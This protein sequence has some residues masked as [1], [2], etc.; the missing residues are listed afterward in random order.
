MEQAKML[1]FEADEI[2][3]KEGELC[4]SMYK[5][6]SGSVILYIRYGEPDEQVVGIYSKSRCFG[7]MNI[8]TSQPSAYTVIAYDKVMLMRIEKD[9]LESFVRQ[10]PQNAIDIMNNMSKSLEMMQ[11]HMELLLD[12][13]YKKDEADK[14]TADDIRLKLIQYGINPMGNW[15]NGFNAKI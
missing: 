13:L 4:S 2:I 15:N 14:K 1:S 11:K 3:I 9:T 12:D 10:N 5:I 6:L 8:F 7:E